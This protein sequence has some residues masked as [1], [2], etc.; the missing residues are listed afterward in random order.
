MP[1]PVAQGEHA[2]PVIRREQLA[3]HVEIGDVV[4]LLV[5]Q[6][7][8]V[9]IHHAAR[10][11]QRAEGAAD[12][13]LLFVI[14]VLAGEDQHRVAV[15]GAMDLIRHGGRQG[16]A[17]IQPRRLGDEKRVQRLERERHGRRSSDPARS[18]TGRPGFVGPSVAPPGRGGQASSGGRSPTQPAAPS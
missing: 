8:L 17:E 9:R 12:I 1:E 18:A 5:L 3:V 6:A 11:L 7:V 15:H 13:H 2:P 10:R 16:L 14:E 4:H